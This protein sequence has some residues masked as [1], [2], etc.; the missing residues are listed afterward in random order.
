M[1]SHFYDG[2]FNFVSDKEGRIEENSMNLKVRARPFQ[3]E[4]LV[5]VEARK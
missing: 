1:L 3:V 5:F 2:Y 4:E